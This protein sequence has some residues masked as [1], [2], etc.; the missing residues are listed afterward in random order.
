MKDAFSG[1][2]SYLWHYILAALVVLGVVFAVVSAWRSTIFAFIALCW[3]PLAGLIL[4]LMAQQQLGL[5]ALGMLATIVGASVVLAGV[6]IALSIGLK[7]KGAVVP[8]SLV[9]GTVVAGAPVLVVVAGWFVQ[10]L[11]GV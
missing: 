5:P 2:D 11:R 4:V 3:L 8:W 1:E 10:V 6:G 7:R 9:F